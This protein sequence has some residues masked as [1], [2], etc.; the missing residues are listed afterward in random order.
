VIDGLVRVSQ[1]GAGLPDGAMTLWDLWALTL[2]LGLV[3]LV[4]E[5]LQTAPTPVH[6]RPLPTGPAAT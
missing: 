3:T 1:R 5:A 2:W 6:T 4:L